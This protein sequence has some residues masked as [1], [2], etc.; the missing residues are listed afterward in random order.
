MVIVSEPL[1]VDVPRGHR[2]DGAGG[3]ALADVVQEPVI[4]MP[5]GT[6]I[7][8]VLE[9]ARTDARLSSGVVLEA[10]APP[11]IIE[12]AARGLGVAVLTPSILGGREGLTVRVIEDLGA[13]ALLALIWRHA[14]A[15]ALRTL[16]EHCRAA[17]APAV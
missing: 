7:R 12:L 17:F 4:C 6:G 1:A 14:P 13:R 8:T 16:L 9:R 3:V 15:P 11:A 2:L 10:S 5:R